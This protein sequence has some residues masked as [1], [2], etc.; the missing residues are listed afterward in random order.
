MLHAPMHPSSVSRLPCFLRPSIAVR[1]H[2][3]LFSIGCAPGQRLVTSSQHWSTNGSA[4]NLSH[5]ED[6]PPRTHRRE[7]R[8]N[9]VVDARRA[10]RP[11]I[12]SAVSVGNHLRLE[13]VAVLLAVRLL[14]LAG[15]DGNRTHPGRLSSAPQTVLKTA[16]LTS[17]GVHRR[18]PQID[19]RRQQSAD[20]RR[21]P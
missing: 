2:R 21:R 7:V 10:W 4:S 11:A 13:A 9:S 18:P 14:K 19:I 1:F 8:A 17:A 3:S 15:M 16:F 20:V 12:T 5:R 6:D